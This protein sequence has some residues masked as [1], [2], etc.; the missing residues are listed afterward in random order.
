MAV[1]WSPKPEKDNQFFSSVTRPGD[2]P[3]TYS[4][5]TRSFFPGMK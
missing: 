1:V 3:N 4:V 2:H 5:D